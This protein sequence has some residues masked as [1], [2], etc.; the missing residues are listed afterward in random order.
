[1]RNQSVR[2]CPV[3]LLLKSGA[4]QKVTDKLARFPL[5][6]AA[7]LAVAILQRLACVTLDPSFMAP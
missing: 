6:I 4:A 5:D 2:W 1:M 7:Q 3:A